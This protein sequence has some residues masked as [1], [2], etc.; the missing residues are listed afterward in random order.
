MLINPVDLLLWTFRRNENDVVKLYDALSPIMEVSTGSDMLNFGYWDE[1]TSHP[2]DA[3][4][5]LCRMIGD[6]AEISSAD[7]IADIGSGILGP[8]KIWNSQYPSLQISSVNV[9]FSQLS[10]VD[11]GNISK[12]NSTARLLPFLD[13]SLDRVIALESAQ[14]FNPIGDFISE[15]NRVLKEN[16]ILALAIPTAIDNSSLSN[17]GILKFTW[18]SEHYSEK[19]ILDEITQNGFEIVDSQDI[20]K[21]VYSPLAEYYISNRDELRKKILSRYSKYVEKILFESMKKMRSSSKKDL[22]GYL[23]VKCKKLALDSC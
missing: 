9:N 16:G 14:H 7:L 23:V 3:Q 5:Q 20:G 12:I 2:V 4:Q 19:Y 15:S 8:A 18:S 21:N 11:S 1:S 17:L 10:S 22:I 6:M 13:S